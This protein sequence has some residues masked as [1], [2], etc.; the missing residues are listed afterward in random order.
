MHKPSQ[1]YLQTNSLDPREPS[2]L[3]SSIFPD[4]PASLEACARLISSSGNVNSA[5]RKTV[6]SNKMPHPVRPS[7]ESGLTIVGTVVGRQT[8]I[9]AFAM[10]RNLVWTVCKT[11]NY[12]VRGKKTRSRTLEQLAAGRWASPLRE[13]VSYGLIPRGTWPDAKR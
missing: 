12:S 7:H 10:D 13:R 3:P 1:R 6:S 8:P 11:A 4:D 5:I 2:D 9:D